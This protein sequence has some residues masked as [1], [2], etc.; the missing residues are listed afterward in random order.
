MYRKENCLGPHIH[1]F[2]K[3]GHYSPSSF[4]VDYSKGVDLRSFLKSKTIVMFR[5]VGMASIECLSQVLRFVT[6]D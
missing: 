2:S 3:S 4:G 6:Y 1:L 5:S